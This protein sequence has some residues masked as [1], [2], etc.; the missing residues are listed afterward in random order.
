LK[1][2]GVALL[3]ALCGALSAS[4]TD[5]YLP[6]KGPSLGE[7]LPFAF[8]LFVVLLT[9][10]TAG[11]LAIPLSVAAW[12]AAYLV[13]VL[14]MTSGLGP[15]ISVCVGGAAGGLGVT[16]CAATGQHRLLS[17]EYLI[18]A[19][20]I[21]GASALP[22]GFW[23]RS[24]VVHTRDPLQPLRLRYAFAIWQ[25]AVGTYLYVVCAQLKKSIPPEDSGTRM[26]EG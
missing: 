14:A 9:P 1:P 7:S 22:F 16:L 6:T 4:L 21:G 23:L 12:L 13:A 2:T 10:K 3:F 15:F 24:F 26:K 5:P 25:A 8:L 11:I 19:A 20:A 18:L 17:S